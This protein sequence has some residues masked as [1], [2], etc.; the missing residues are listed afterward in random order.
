MSEGD[1]IKVVNRGKTWHT[2]T[3]SDHVVDT[4]FIGPAGHKHNGEEEEVG[5]YYLELSELQAGAWKYFCKLHP[6]MQVE[7][8]TPGFEPM[9]LTQASKIPLPPPAQRGLGE[10]WVGLQ[11]YANEGGPDGAIQVIN[12]TNWTSSLITQVGNNPHNGWFG[13]AADMQ[14]RLRNISLWANWHDVGVTVID[15]DTKRVLGNAPVGA[16]NAHVMTAPN[17]RTQLGADRW[18]VTVMGSNKVQ[19][20]DPFKFM[21]YQEPT[22][23]AI[24]Q[25]DGVNGRPGMSPHGLWFA[26]DGDH[27]LTANTLANTV[28]LYSVSKPWS[29]G[30]GRSGIGCELDQVQTGGRVP[31]AVSVMNPGNP[32][33]TIYR[34]FSNNAATGD[35]SVFEVRTAEGNEGLIKVMVGAPFGNAAGNIALRDL[36]ATPIRWAS[37]PIQ[38][39]VSPPDATEHGRYMVV[40]N[41]ASFNVS[42]IALDSSGN[43]V[44]IYTFP[45]GLGAHGVAFGRKKMEGWGR[46]DRI[47]YFAYVTNTFENYVS[48]YDLELLERMRRLERMGRAPRE[49]RPGG[50]RE[51]VRLEGYAAQ[52]LTGRETA[53]VPITLLS[54]DARGVVHV[55]DIALSASPVGYRSA[56]LKEHVWVNLPGYGMV[57]LDLDVRTDTGAM[58]VFCRPLPPPW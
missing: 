27:F 23:G 48:V 9:P 14:G 13:T 44:G 54:P 18:F 45:A 7:I 49:F 17:N 46:G 41:K 30:E 36:T 35:I 3:S 1:Y 47:A 42:V 37:M 2:V 10:V 53:T 58:G 16:A 4:G 6:Y 56:Y 21:H 20:V 51:R 22:I 33:A 5:Y 25:A 39:A 38:C 26:D 19:E 28:S 12:A 8:V 34:G 57:M 40:C 31:L 29:D 50:A 55:G 11:T 32:S 15:A 24:S 52:L 43:P